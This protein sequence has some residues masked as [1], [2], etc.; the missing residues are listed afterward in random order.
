MTYELEIS[1]DLDKTFFKLS[2]KD[3]L[4]FEILTKKI[5]QIVENPYRA[6]LLF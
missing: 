6:S 5:E 3:K 4:H 2:K 1:E